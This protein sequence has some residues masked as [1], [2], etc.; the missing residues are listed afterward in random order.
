M[1]L[2]DAIL[3]ADALTFRG[4]AVV[5]EVADPAHNDGKGGNRFDAVPLSVFERDQ[6][7]GRYMT[8]VEIRR[9]NDER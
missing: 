2:P 9:Q 6:N 7:G 8:L 1:T 5:V 3:K 4:L